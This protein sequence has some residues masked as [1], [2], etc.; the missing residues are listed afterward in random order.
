MRVVMWKRKSLLLS[1]ALISIYLSH[2]VAIPC[3]FRLGSG[4]L[5]R[6]T[7]NVGSLV[8]PRAMGA[9]SY[10]RHP[11]EPRT[12]WSTSSRSRTGVAEMRELR[13]V[14][15]PSKLSTSPGGTGV[16]AVGDNTSFP[17]LSTSPGGT[18]VAAMGNYSSWRS[19]SSLTSR[20][21][22]AAQEYPELNATFQTDFRFCAFLQG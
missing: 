16:A 12:S 7:A 10:L 4:A 22:V 2:S 21:G 19:T 11:A 18:G 14:E 20:T 13:Q 15:P 5:I 17:K 8:P 6:F 1:L 9:V 3:S